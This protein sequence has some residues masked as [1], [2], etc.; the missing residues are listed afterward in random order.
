[1]EIKK[2]DL[3]LRDANLLKQSEDKTKKKTKKRH[4]NKA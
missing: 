4:Y 2:N 1:M 3:N